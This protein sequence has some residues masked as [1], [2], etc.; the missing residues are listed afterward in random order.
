[1]YVIL[2]FSV[3]SWLMIS[4]FA[5]AMV[6]AES[7]LQYGGVP[8]STSHRFIKLLTAKFGQTAAERVSF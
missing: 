2:D 7:N 3:K 8:T 6:S 4:D 1:V 5:A